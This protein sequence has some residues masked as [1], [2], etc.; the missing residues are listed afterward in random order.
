MLTN[1]LNCQTFFISP[2]PL[3][4]IIS[5]Q[6]IVYKWGKKSRKHT[7][8]QPNTAHTQ[9]LNNIMSCAI[10]EETKKFVLTPNQTK[11]QRGEDTFN[12]TGIKLSL[13]QLIYHF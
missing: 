3:S 2:C 5:K 12:I 11:D 9:K 7:S 1:S 8:E 13:F 10:N 6:K 4:D